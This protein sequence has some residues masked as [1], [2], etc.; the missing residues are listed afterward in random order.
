MA[1]PCERG[2]EASGSGAT[3]LFIN[4][5]NYAFLYAKMIPNKRN[6]EFYLVYNFSISYVTQSSHQGHFMPF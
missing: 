2:D 4:R 6:K 3:E 1:G 5:I